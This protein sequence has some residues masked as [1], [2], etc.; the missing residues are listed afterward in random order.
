MGK[1]GEQELAKQK[2]GWKE[3]EK[4][5]WEEG[6]APR[7]QRCSVHHLLQRG[8][9]RKEWI[10]QESAKGRASLVAQW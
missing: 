9:G 6:V 7:M 4:Q 8:Q 5:G 1:E 10:E 3:N 2:R